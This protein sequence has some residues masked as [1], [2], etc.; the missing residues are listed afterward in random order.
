MTAG[1]GRAGPGEAGRG[2]AGPGGA[3]RGPCKGILDRGWCQ[4]YVYKVDRGELEG[5]A[6]RVGAGARLL[7]EAVGGGHGVTSDLVALRLAADLNG[8]AAATLRAS[9]ERAREQG[10]TWQEIGDV[11]GV[12]RQAAF[13]RFGNPVDPRTGVPMNANVRS[14]AAEHATQLIIDW[15]AGDYAAMSRD[16]NEEMATKASA[17]QMADAFAQITGMVGAYEG[18]GDPVVRQWGDYTVVD[19][20]LRFEA[21]EL[22]GRVSYDQDGKVAGVFALPPDAPGTV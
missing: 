19:I 18:M 5:L 22:N 3:G 17:A 14:E 2:R 12:T 13:Q 20:P 8:L 15:F 21:G 4:G 10:R 11:L 9:V 6:D 1:R 16:F 7:G